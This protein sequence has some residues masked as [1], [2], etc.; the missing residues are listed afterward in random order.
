MKP[1]QSTECV[2]PSTQNTETLPWGR[3]AIRRYASQFRSGILD[4]SPSRDYC[5]MVSGPL[6]TLLEAMGVPARL[7]SG[8]MSAHLRIVYSSTPIPEMA[9]DLARKGMAD[10][11]TNLCALG[12]NPDAAARWVQWHRDNPHNA[13]REALDKARAEP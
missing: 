2:P 13:V 5:Y 4:G 12:A 10:D 9:F 6:S 8:N 7:V 11:Y 1:Q 3:K